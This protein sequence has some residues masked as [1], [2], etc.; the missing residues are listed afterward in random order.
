VSLK[1]RAE[2]DGLRAFAVVPVILFHADFRYFSGGFIGVDIF[3]V[4]SGYLITTILIEDIENK[5]F[6]VLRFYERRARRILPALFLVMACCLPFSFF[7]MIP[8]QFEDFSKS[9]VA[10]SFF[11]SNILFWRQ[12]G[13]FDSSAEEKPLL[14]TWSLAVE[15]QY[16]LLFPLFLFL[17]WKYGKTKVFW[18]ILLS[19]LASLLLSEWGWRNKANANFYLAPTRAWELF[20]GSIAAFIIYGQGAKRSDLLSLVGFSA[21]VFSIFAFDEGVP[22]PS[23]YSVVPVAGVFLVIVYGNGETMVAK[24]LA[25]KLL[26]GIGLVSYSAYLWHQP[27]F[28]FARLRSLEQPD[29]ATMLAL[30]ALS[31]LLAF[32]SWRFVETPFRAKSHL[33]LTQLQVFKFSVAGLLFFSLVGAVGI[34]SNGFDYRLTADQKEIL[35][36]EKFPRQEAYREGVC[37][38]LP[39]QDFQKFNENCIKST[40]SLVWGDSHAAALASGWLENGEVI[41]QL[42]ASACPPVLGVSI[43]HRP[44]CKRINDHTLHVIEEIKFA[45]VILHANWVS[46]D[47]PLIDGLS[48]TVKKLK[49]LGINR[50][51]IVG[52]VPQYRPSLPQRLIAEGYHRL[53]S[54][55]RSLAEINTVKQVDRTLRQIASEHD[56]SFVSA[57]ETLCAAN[58]CDS[59][60]ETKGR[61]TPT[62]W[63]YGHLTP[64]GAAY[65]IRRF[66]WKN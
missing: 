32:G 37:L 46:Y 11:V 25:N 30:S 56:V 58:R 35:D 49:S 29:T 22:F 21:I 15:E 59:V 6:S 41:S 8:S 26:V 52:G 51:T 66:P 24:F 19:G 17:F 44:H 10:V 31:I 20:A 63:D 4:I 61:Y 36:Y 54:S 65:L 45:H 23:L 50:I 9:L 48:L 57:L 53:S 55:H 39:E 16:Y 1:Y 14:H 7:W 12:S 3:F 28:A 62:A 47:E 27:L 33:F 43:A 2:I 64:E 13:Y 18:I 38:L 34:F 42:T 40:N 60:I 5:N